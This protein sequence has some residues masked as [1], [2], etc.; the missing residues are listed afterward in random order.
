[1]HRNPYNGHVIKV[2][3]L[4]TKPSGVVF[5]ECGNGAVG[6]AVGMSRGL[7]LLKVLPSADKKIYIK[8]KKK[9]IKLSFVCCRWG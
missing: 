8:K 9:L 7:I 5:R 3:I 2:G 1:M 6:V 4:R